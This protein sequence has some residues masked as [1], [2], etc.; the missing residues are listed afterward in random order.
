MQFISQRFFLADEIS[1]QDKAAVSRVFD[2]L[3]NDAEESDLLFSSGTKEDI[4]KIK[5]ITTKIKTNYSDIIFIGTGA[6]YTI[7]KMVIN[8]A[9]YR[10][11][12]NFHF[13]RNFDSDHLLHL[14]NKL[15]PEKTFII[16]ISKSG[17][18]AEVLINLLKL[19]E[20]LEG[21]LT[22]AKIKEHFLIITEEKFTPL[23][24]ISQKLG[25]E[26]I[27]HPNVGGRFAVFTAIGL[28]PAA[29]IDFDINK[30]V[31][32]SKECLKHTIKNKDWIIEAVTYN[33]SLSKHYINSVLLSY[34]E[35]LIGL[36]EWHKQLIAESLGK[37]NCGIVPIV[38][39]GTF[40]QHVQLQ[41]FLDGSKD[42]Y[43]TVCGI[44]NACKDLKIHNKLGI[45]SLDYFEN[46]SIFDI[47][48]MNMELI[49][50]KLK[51]AKKNIRII[52][53]SKVCEESL[54]EIVVTEFIELMVIAKLKNI[55]PF[56]QP[57]IEDI[58]HRI[59][60]IIQNA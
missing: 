37:K 33:Y 38:A 49:L 55:N 17:N 21:K 32:Y 40:D 24:E 58:K 8:F 25:C 7:P 28:L 16:S 27:V 45:S 60:E 48:N 34:G 54:V 36:N 29:L 9:Q 19:Y 43:F 51:L 46:K 59:K 31:S 50:D 44:K 3:F 23:F 18:S 2:E 5:K 30:I 22:R 12:V 20:W 11:R 10:A 56:N 53:I 26:L 15:N 35:N 52:E 41:L 39:I 47:L 42:L 1:Q 57:A 13:L 4:S 14:T 6:S